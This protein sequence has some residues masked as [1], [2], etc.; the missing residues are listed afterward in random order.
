MNQR[1]FA[2][3]DIVLAA[4]GLVA[5][6]S[7][8]LPWYK[9]TE[10]GSV[11]GT[12]QSATLTV[13]GWNSPSQGTLDGQT[14]TGPLV[15]IAMLLLL[16]FGILALRAL[17]APQLVAGKLYYQIG[18]GV[19]AL[20]VILV[21]V[22]WLTF[23]KPPSDE[24][25]ITLNV[26]S[27]ADFG[28]YLGLLAALAFA[29]VSFWGMGQS[30][31][32]PGGALGA[33]AFG[34]YPGQPQQPQFGQQPYGQQQPQYGQPPQQ[35]PQQPY[36]QQQYPQQPQQPYG[37]PPQQPQYGQQPQY[38]Q[39]PYDQ[40]QQQPQY[41]PQPQQ[42]YG[43]QPPQYPQQPQQPY[44]QPPQQPQYPQQPQQPQPPYGQQQQQQPPQQ[45][46]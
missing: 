40:S 41:P 13:N 24:D 38:P 42:P 34:G 11:G 35:Q 44:G 46:S 8:F 32:A 36:G 20:S 18:I 29:G 45:W 6:I 27:G 43:Q 22:R 15:W 37:Q 16:I 26:S 31:A 30:A 23:F 1:K 9:A 14:I 4:A 10:S 5:L 28:L 2:T 39:Q 21:V 25:G 7:T 12:S 3:P 33:P 19:G 17:F